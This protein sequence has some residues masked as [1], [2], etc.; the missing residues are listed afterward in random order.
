MYLLRITVTTFVSLV[1][2]KSGY[3]LEM[4]D[5]I[6]YERWPLVTGKLKGLLYTLGTG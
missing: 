6:A 5:V 4:N 1:P 2:F 3:L